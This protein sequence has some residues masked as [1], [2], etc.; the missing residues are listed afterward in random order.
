MPIGYICNDTS[1]TASLPRISVYLGIRVYRRKHMCTSV[2]ILRD[3]SPATPELFAPCSRWSLHMYRLCNL[4]YGLH[5][6]NRYR[7]ICAAWIQFNPDA[8]CFRE[9]L[10]NCREISS[11]DSKFHIEWPAREI[12]CRRKYFLPGYLL[13]C[14]ITFLALL[15]S[16]P[17][18]SCG[19]E[20]KI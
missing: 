6:I 1:S 7:K 19:M 10:C 20:L 15:F 4:Q 8:I 16:P 13:K 3:T 12:Q 18:F 5:Q 14:F 11:A 2:R 17:Q 9:K